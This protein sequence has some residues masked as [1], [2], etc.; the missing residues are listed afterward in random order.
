MQGMRTLGPKISH[1]GHGDP[2]PQAATSPT[3]GLARAR[4]RQGCVEGGGQPVLVEPTVGVAVGAVAAV[5]VALV[6][7]AV[8]AVA[9]VALALVVA[10]VVA[11]LLLL[12]Q[13]RL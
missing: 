6:R 10:A 1:A 8:S 3:Q 13:P 5:A 9:A 11:V 2:G 12:V 7:M 4:S